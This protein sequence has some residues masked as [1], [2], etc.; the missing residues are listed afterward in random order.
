MTLVGEWISSDSLGPTDCLCLQDIYDN[1]ICMV[2]G[3]KTLLLYSPAEHH[4]L[5]STP[6][7][8]S[9]LSVDLEKPNHKALPSFRAATRHIATLE[10]GDCLYPLWGIQMRHLACQS[11]FQ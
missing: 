5:Q 6:T 8:T 7:P 11:H 4:L 10:K 9:Y 2:Q 1:L 3:R